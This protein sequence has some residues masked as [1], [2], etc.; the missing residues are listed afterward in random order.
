MKEKLSKFTEIFYTPILIY[1]FLLLGISLLAISSSLPLA[2]VQH[3]ESNFVPRQV[4]FF[5][6]GSVATITVLIIGIK[7]IRLIRWPLYGLFFFLLIPILLFGHPESNLF[8]EVNG[9][10]RWINL[11]VMSLQP[12]EFLR[13]ALI[14]VVADIIQKHNEKI[15]HENRTFKSD[16]QLILKSFGVVLLPSVLIFIQPDSGITILILITTSLML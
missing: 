4:M 3:P 13:I 8:P 7:N 5:I 12:S 2:L 10:A 9:A 6:I 11:G 15:P 1:F 14:L 16:F